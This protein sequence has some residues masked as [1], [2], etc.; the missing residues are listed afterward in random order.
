MES[1][2]TVYYLPIGFKTQG[3]EKITTMISKMLFQKFQK[4]APRAEGIDW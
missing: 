3:H 4:R 2:I 1:D